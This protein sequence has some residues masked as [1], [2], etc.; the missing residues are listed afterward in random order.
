M[1]PL[2]LYEAVQH[3]K[4]SMNEHGITPP[5]HIEPGRLLRFSTNG[6]AG[7]KAGWCRLFED[8][9]GGGGSVGFLNRPYAGGGYGGNGKQY[10]AGQ[11]DH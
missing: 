10:A 9:R 1:A 2:S 5:E 11:C 3:F 7:D 6:K 4:H 8:L